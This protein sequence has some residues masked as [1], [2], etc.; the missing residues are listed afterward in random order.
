MS[1]RNQLNK[2]VTTWKAAEQIFADIDSGD[3][4]DDDN[5]SFP[6]AAYMS[7]DS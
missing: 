3:N 1:Q 2:Q 4:F 7:Q 5:V 6:S